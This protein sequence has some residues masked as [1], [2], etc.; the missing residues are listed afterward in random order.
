MGKNKHIRRLIRGEDKVITEHEKYIADELIK[1]YSSRQDI[2]KWRKDIARHE[3]IKAKLLA[4][5]PGRKE[6]KR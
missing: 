4:K 1:P 2:A 6:G 5:L 3:R